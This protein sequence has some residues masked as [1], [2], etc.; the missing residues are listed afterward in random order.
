MPYAIIRIAKLKQ[1]NIA[2]SGMHVSRTR[3]TPNA[4]KDKLVENQTIIH[5]HDLDLPLAEVVEQKI[6]STPQQR[7]I[8]TDA[9]HCVEILLTASPEYF[10]PDRPEEYGAYQADRL[11]NWQQATIGWLKQEYGDRI[12]RAEL[13]NDEATPHIHAYLVPID[14]A[15]QLNCKKMFGDRKKMFALQDSYAAAMKPLGLERGIKGS[16]AEHTDVKDYYQIVNAAAS[17]DLDHL[18]VLR[19]KAAAYELLKRDKAKLDR[20]L[21]AIANER[22]KLA[23]QLLVTQQQLDHRVKITLAIDNPPQQISLEQVASELGLAP[24]QLSPQVNPLDLVKASLNLNYQGATEW[25]TTRFGTSQAIQLTTDLARQIIAQ[26]PPAPFMPPTVANG[27]WGDKRAWLTQTMKLPAQLVDRL[28]DQG[29]IYADTE[30]QLICLQRNLDL[31]VTGASALDLSMSNPQWDLVPGSSSTT[32]W[33]FFESSPLAQ[34]ERVV[35]VSKPIESLVYATLHPSKQPTL[36]LT[37]NDGGWL[38]SEILTVE[39]LTIATNQP[40]IGVPAQ[41]KSHTPTS[42]TWRG[43][44]AAFIEEQ[45]ANTN[46]QPSPKPQGYS[47][48]GR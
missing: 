23:Q 7:K 32:G 46:L 27:L 28:H 22:D 33:Y 10:R 48:G 45:M 21:K 39:D 31:Q 47:R 6:N 41:S 3:H 40:L 8:R 29:L 19:T 20:Q 14:A 16:Q 30:E 2:G 35:I 1:S 34:V 5:N 24:T 25:L 4:D 44:L 37:A 43:D 18:Q 26:T 38:P 13:H 15:G 36:Y 9:V 42:G 17:H 12:V 11:A